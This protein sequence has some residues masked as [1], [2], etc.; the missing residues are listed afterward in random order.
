MN[1]TL[2]TI[3][4]ILSTIIIID[5]FNAGHALMIFLLAGIIPGTDIVISADHA[6]TFTLALFGLVCGRATWS[7]ALTFSGL[8]VGR[9]DALRPQG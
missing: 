8:F 2:T 7:L 5:V 3:F 4:L 6:F 9:Q 1:K